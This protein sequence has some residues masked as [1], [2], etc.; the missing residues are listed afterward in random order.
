[1]PQYLRQIALSGLV[2][3]ALTACGTA[4]THNAQLSQAQLDFQSASVQS[5]IMALAPAEMGEAAA[6]LKLANL[7]QQREA[8]A[9]EINHLAYL[10][11]QRVAIAR[12]VARQRGA[13]QSVAAAGV[14]RDRMRLSART[15]EADEAHQAARTS[16]Q[17]AEEAETRNQDL[18]AQLKALNARPTDQGMVVTIGDVL[19]ASGQT[20]LRPGGAHQL[21]KLVAFLLQHPRQTALIE[22]HTDSMGAQ[23]YNQRLSERRADA[24]RLHLLRMGVAP[25]RVSTRGAGESSPIASNDSASGRQ[26]NRRVDIILTGDGQGSARR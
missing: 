3:A 11:T 5:D 22:G 1:M 13:E 2:A 17:S 24:V 25:H 26:R 15:S 10:A 23:A 16:R 20:Q 4:P 12:E 7:A 9:M 19:F 18:E 21:D 6:A 8:S 14:A